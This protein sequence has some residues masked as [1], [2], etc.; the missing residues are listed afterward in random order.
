MNPCLP[1]L[2]GGMTLRLSW[3]LLTAAALAA[4][5]G[6]AQGPDFQTPAAPLTP[7]SAN[8]VT[9]YTEQALAETTASAP[10]T[11]G[12]PQHW[13]SGQQHPGLTAQ[14]WTLFQSTALNG[15]LQQALD[16]NPSL[17]AAKASLKQAEESYTALYGTLAVP[18]AGLELGAGR[19][20]TSI[21]QTGAPSMTTNLYNAS[22]NVSYTID[23]FGA[24]QRS[25]EAQ[26]ASVDYQRFQLEAAKLALTANV[27]TTA[28]REASI[29]DQLQATRELLRLQTE[30]LQVLEQQFETGGVG[31]N[32]VLS[33]KALV[34]NTKTL[35]PPLE[36]SLAQARHQLAIYVGQ[37]PSD[38]QLPA[39][40]LSQL[41]LP[42]ELPVSMAS[43]LVR[44]RPDIRASEALWHQ[45]SAQVGVA[46]A[47]LYPQINLTASVGA[48]AIN[49]ADLLSEKWGFWNLMG[50]L[51]QPVFNGGALTA[52]KRAAEAAYQAAGEQYRGTV[53]Q[54]FQNV[55]DSLT[56]LSH[57]AQTLQA[58]A[59]AENLAQQLLDLSQAQYQAG[60]VS[61]LSLL[62]AQRNYQQAHIATVSARAARL[63]DTA[64]LFQSLGGGWWQPSI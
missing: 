35:L 64:A 1:T 34:S 54:A 8:G 13:V 19:E 29:R 15:L 58:Q 4:L 57:D 53:L 14:W 60:G 23:L 22:V 45:A 25:L 56:A 40:E 2:R 50:G 30:Q 3:T 10:G 47:N 46:T 61:Y 42:Q 17:E 24:N 7:T 41:H 48:A 9:R 59:E 27:V 33:Q 20:K 52:K 21:A 5:S 36:K 55:A 62:D 11:L 32:P 44:Q 51:T 12:E 18:N 6:C 63:A 39:F 16:H 31:L 38:A 49:P 43:E 37:L 26:L 28:I